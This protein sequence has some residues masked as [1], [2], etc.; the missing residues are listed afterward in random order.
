MTIQ[1]QRKRRLLA[2]RRCYW[3]AHPARD[4]NLDHR[5]ATFSR[6]RDALAGMGISLVADAAS[7]A[8]LTFL[9][10]AGRSP[11][12]RPGA[13]PD[14]STLRIAESQYSYTMVAVERLVCP[15]CGRATLERHRMEFHHET[16]GVEDFGYVD[17]C[18]FCDRDGWM[19]AGHM[20]S[21]VAARRLA[22]KVVP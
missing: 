18:S 2:T 15:R 8:G 1:W 22:A 21:V 11:N 6:L 5:S 3:I 20:P 19:F 9:G 7:Q 14:Y 13:G 17:G 12:L 4:P 10:G 16:S